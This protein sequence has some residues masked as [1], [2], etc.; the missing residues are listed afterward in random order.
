MN[1]QQARAFRDKLN[2][3]IK[4]LDEV[5]ANNSQIE[6]SADFSAR[7]EAIVKSRQK[8][9][10]RSRKA[11][12]ANG[13]F[14]FTSIRELDNELAI[15]WIKMGEYAF[16]STTPVAIWLLRDIRISERQLRENLKNNPF[17]QMYIGSILF[18]IIKE[19]EQ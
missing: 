9:G 11:S 17:T 14:Y 4:E 6:S 5:I 1:A 7:V 18:D 12:L 3:L 13:K 8:P 15:G 19:N 2:E 10:V 16:V